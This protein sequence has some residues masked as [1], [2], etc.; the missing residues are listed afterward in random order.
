[1]VWRCYI[2]T[3]CDDREILDAKFE[4]R[5]PKS[6][7]NASWSPASSPSASIIPRSPSWV[8]DFSVSNCMVCDAA[9]TLLVRRHHCRRCGKLTCHSC[10]PRNNSRPILEWGLKEPVRH[11]RDCFKSPSIAWKDVAPTATPSVPVV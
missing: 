10:A 6:F 9:F 1:M 8:P 11:C 3:L 2:V 4:K 5:E 7:D